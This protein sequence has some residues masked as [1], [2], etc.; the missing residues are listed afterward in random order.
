M[1]EHLNLHE[2]QGQAGLSRSPF[3]PRFGDPQLEAEWMVERLGA[4]RRIN[5]RALWVLLISSLVFVCV[6]VAVVG[7]SFDILATRVAFLIGNAAALVAVRKV[8]T[9]Q[10]GDGLIS[11]ATVAGASVIWF[12]IFMKLPLELVSAYWMVTS[13]M[14]VI[15]VFVLIEAML[16]A[17][18]GLALLVLAMTMSGPLALGLTL[19]HTALALMHLGVVAAVGW[20]AAW[21]VEVARRLA[22]ARQLGVERERA[23]TVDLLRNVLPVSIAD[24]LLSQPGTIAERHDDVTVLFADIVGFTPWASSCEATEV[25][26]VLDQIFSAFDRLCDEH[27]VEKIKTIGDAYMAAGGVPAGSSG[28]ASGVVRLALGMMEVVAGV[29]TQGGTTLQLRIGVHRGPVVAGVIGRRK[30]IYDL[31]G[32]TVNTAARMESHGVPGRVQVT[33][34]VAEQ[35]DEG[36]V[37]EPRGTIEVKGKGPMKAY[38]VALGS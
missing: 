16:L 29:H 21:Q 34:A 3:R 17:R 37:A 15:G 6:D 7:S 14:L 9:I 11:V 32:D 24:R 22:F 23:R 36:L 8:R 19:E 25:V 28:T 38:L 35:L 27:G 20:L 33:E 12:S 1:S 5:G 10:Q 30:F 26:E 18:L 4:F 13:A 31:W 2:V